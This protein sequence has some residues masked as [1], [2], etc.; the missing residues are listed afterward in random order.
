M[1]TQQ[2]PWDVPCDPNTLG[3]YVRSRLLRRRTDGDE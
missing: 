1:L 2:Q 3:V